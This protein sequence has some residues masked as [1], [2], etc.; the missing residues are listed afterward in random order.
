M[1]AGRL[2]LEAWQ[3][4]SAVVRALVAVHHML[5]KDLKIHQAC[6]PGCGSLYIQK[7]EVAEEM[8][9]AREVHDKAQTA[10]RVLSSLVGGQDDNLVATV[11]KAL[12]FEHVPPLE[13]LRHN[14]RVSLNALNAITFKLT[15]EL[16]PQFPEVILF[17]GHGLPSELGVLWRPAQTLD[18]FDE[19]V[20]VATESKHTIW[21][22]RNGQEFFAIK[23][24]KIGQACHLRTCL[25]EAM[26]IYRQRHPAIVEIKALF[27]GSGNESSFYMQMPWYENG[28]LDKWVAGENGPDWQKVRS[29]LLDT[30]LGLV[31]LH[32][33]GVIHSDVKPANVLVDSRER[34]RLADF[35][36][37][38]DTKDT[39]LVSSRV[40]H[41]T[42]MLAT[43]RGWTQDFAAPELRTSGQATK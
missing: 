24:Y 4:E 27:Q 6:L 42:T 40:M 10:L 21:R 18:S 1:H 32:D 35:D 14:L 39:S 38:I 34:G 29:V 30:L 13:D 41:N 17:I 2:L 22:V 11:A 33:N 15:G 28:S 37:S 7:D 43:A 31:H 12:G 26:V 23:E 36:I 8:R 5:E 19:K 16:L 25:K 20:L 9:S 3:A